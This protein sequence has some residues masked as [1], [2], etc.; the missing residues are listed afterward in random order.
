MQKNPKWT[1][2]YKNH[3]P[4]RAFLYIAP[5]GKK[6]DTGRTVPRSLRYF[7]VYNHLGQISA[8]HAKN[9]IGRIP[10]SKAKGL[11]E[12]KVKALQDK[13]R[14]LYYEAGG[15]AGVRKEKRK[16]AKPKRR[17]K[18]AAPSIPK[19][20]LVANPKR[21][22]HKASS[23]AK[24]TQRIVRRNA[25]DTKD[26]HVFSFFVVSGTS[27]KII[28]GYA[29]RERAREDAKL[30]KKA[31]LPVRI[32]SRASLE[33]QGLDPADDKNWKVGS[34]SKFRKL[35]EERS[36]RPRWAR[37]PAH[38]A[39]AMAPVIEVF[40]RER[41]KAAKVHPKLLE[42]VLQVDPEIHDT[43]R[44]FAQTTWDTDIGVVAI[45]VAPELAREPISVIRGIIRHE[46]GHAAVFYGLEPA[47][48]KR[49]AS[50][51]SYEALERGADVNAERIFGTKIYYDER[52]VEVSGPGARG[53]R[54]RPLGLR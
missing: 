33:K 15:M 47:W 42:V 21:K 43:E 16:P 46:F 54:P 10:Q 23:R 31:N 40:E 22:L 8:S 51:E 1:T 30:Y 34:G 25:A 14:K 24:A 48:P 3:L 18:A 7:P 45:Q 28:S 12:K 37:N 50:M 11:T 4:D 44:A 2:K 41:E 29:T 5:G 9:A 53:K 17:K 52:G 26:S 27:G 13:A 49:F 35:L 36:T 32:L 39:K 6:D 20:R 38:A 19:L